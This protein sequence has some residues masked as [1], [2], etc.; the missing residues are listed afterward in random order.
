M[1]AQHSSSS[2]IY[3]L[4][5][6]FSFVF[7]VWFTSVPLLCG[8][9]SCI[10]NYHHYCEIFASRADHSLS[11]TVGRV[12]ISKSYNL[13]FVH[14]FFFTNFLVPA[15]QLAVIIA[16]IIISVRIIYIYFILCSLH[17]CCFCKL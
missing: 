4:L 13:G 9:L 11:T 15:W 8:L 7:S 2:R 10:F 1:L 16:G 3:F 6:T 5:L 17:F 12:F 14:L